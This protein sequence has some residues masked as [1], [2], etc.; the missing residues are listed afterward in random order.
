MSEPPRDAIRIKPVV[1]A[2]R[3]L[4]LVAGR[5]FSV[6]V[7]PTFLF[8]EQTDDYFAWTIGNPLIAAFLGAAFWSSCALEI[9]LPARRCGHAHGWR[10][11]P[12]WSSRS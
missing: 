1:P 7:T 11:R 8:S 5:W 2:M 4:L 3:W 9:Y 6:R 10:S 12:S